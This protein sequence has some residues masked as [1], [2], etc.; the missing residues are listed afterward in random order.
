M[1]TYAGHE[2]LTS[3]PLGD[4]KTGATVPTPAAGSGTLEQFVDRKWAVRPGPQKQGQLERRL[5]FSTEAIFLTAHLPL[6]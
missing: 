1:V 6:W 2:Y 4:L 5:P 3:G